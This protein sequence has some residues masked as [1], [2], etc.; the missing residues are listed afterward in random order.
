MSLNPKTTKDEGL[1]TAPLNIKYEELLSAKVTPSNLVL[2][3]HYKRILEL[4]RFLDNSLSF[5]KQRH[6]HGAQGILFEDLKSSV[7]KTYGKQFDMKS[8]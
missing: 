4:S 2:P 6:A 7:E 8:F 5:I 3:L 1:L